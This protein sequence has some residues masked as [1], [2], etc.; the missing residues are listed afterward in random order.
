MRV[1]GVH[2]RTVWM[3]DETIY[4]IDQT[5]LPH[6]FEI[7]DIK[8]I[9]DL[10]QAINEMKV[11]GAGAIG[12][13]GGYGM[14]LAGMQAVDSKFFMSVELAAKE[15]KNTRPTAQSLFTIIDRLLKMIKLESDPQKARTSLV[16]EATY[17]AEMDIEACKQIG[18]NGSE[19]IKDGT[20]ISTHCNAGWLAFVDWGSALSPIFYAVK[21][22]G[23]NIFVYVDETRPRCQ[24]SR[25]TAWELLE[26]NIPHTII[27][28]NVTGAL[29]SSGKI[30]LVIVG[31]DR[32]AMNGDIA[33]KIGTYS[34]AVLA[35]ENGIPFY[36]AA[37]V[38]TIDLDCESGESIPIEERDEDEVLYMFGE[39][40]NCNIS[41]VRI[42]PMGC[43]ALNICFDVTPAKY[44]TGIITERGIFSASRDG[45]ANILKGSISDS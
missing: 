43:T 40:E 14:A 38:T 4:M 29:M 42:S 37:P 8:C 34:S 31:A 16:K 24:G 1:N 18:K 23:K 35:K 28:D 41:K 33:N 45:I 39:D 17:Y 9:D 19:L 22:Q 5:K 27:S 32:I 30:D 12:V 2:Y 11:R 36:I 7:I 25:L 20:N 10:K 3:E 21:E 13:A 15:L 44:I 6:R 26:E